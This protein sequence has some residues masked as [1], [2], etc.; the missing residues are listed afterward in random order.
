[1]DEHYLLYNAKIYIS[2]MFHLLAFKNSKIQSRG[3][4]FFM[5]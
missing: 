4:W 1:M 5:G 2:H 3:S